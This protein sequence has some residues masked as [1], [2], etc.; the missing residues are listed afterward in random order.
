MKDIEKLGCI[1]LLIFLGFL[2][3]KEKMERSENFHNYWSWCRPTDFKCRE[4]Y[5][6][7]NDHR[8][9]YSLRPNF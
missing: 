2:Y 8:P 4:Y 3:F 7:Y 1:I 6:T 9:Y 5:K